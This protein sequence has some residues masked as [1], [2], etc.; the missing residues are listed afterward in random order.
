MKRFLVFLLV[1][2]LLIGS[3]V[4][5]YLHQE[6]KYSD[7]A[8]EAFRKSGEGGVS[9]EEMVDAVKTEFERITEYG[10]K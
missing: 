9:P 6:K 7:A 2:G 10:T 3:I 4:G 1:A 5:L 8:L